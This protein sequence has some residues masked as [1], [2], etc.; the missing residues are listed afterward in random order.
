MLGFPLKP[1]K[2]IVE[3]LSLPV[4]TD[5]RSV[6]DVFLLLHVVTAQ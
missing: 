5:A 4:L 1:A 2:Y 6:F 3:I